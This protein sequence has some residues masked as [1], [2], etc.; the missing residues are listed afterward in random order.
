MK[1]ECTKCNKKKSILKFVKDKYKKDGY[2]SSCKKCY[3]VYLDSNRDNINARQRKYN[4]ENRN[5]SNKYYRERRQNDS[6]FRLEC[7]LRRRI[8]HCFENKKPSKS[9]KQLLGAD[10]KTVYNHIESLFT[11][12][13]S[14]DKV[15]LEI[16]IDHKTP[17]SS[18]KNEKELISLFHYKNLQP[19]WALDNFRKG[20]KTI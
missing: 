18:A 9:T 7:N 2:R 17:L 16:H 14:W 10:Y 1:K 5:V 3:K 13:M 11:K 15:G 8:N 6:L 19:L 20:S 12:G 4:K